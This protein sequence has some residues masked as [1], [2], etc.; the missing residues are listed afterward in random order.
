M[1]LEEILADGYIVTINGDRYFI[2]RTTGGGITRTVDGRII[3]YSPPD[4][5]VVKRIKE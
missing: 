4:E 5:L 3:H 1:E 2:V